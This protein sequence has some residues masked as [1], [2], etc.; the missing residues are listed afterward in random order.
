[1]WCM[2][3]GKLA[4]TLN[5]NLPPIMSFPPFGPRAQAALSC[6]IGAA[7]IVVCSLAQA[8]SQEGAQRIVVTAARTE[9]ALPDALP[10]TRVTSRAEIEATQATDLPSL[11][12][13]L[14]SIDVAQ[15]G[16]VGSQTSLFLRGADSRPR[17][18]RETGIDATTRRDP[19]CFDGRSQLP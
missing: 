17:G 14:T 4:R 18:R 9:Q 12:R 5:R 2:P 15:T 8:Q 1:M 10:S 11:L 3:A 19:E 7:P 6:L 16:P 13:A